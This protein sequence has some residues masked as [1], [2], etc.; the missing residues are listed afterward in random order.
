MPTVPRRGFVASLN[1]E[2]D[3]NDLWQLTPSVSKLQTNVKK[4]QKDN[5]NLGIEGV[6]SLS[7]LGQFK[8]KAAAATKCDFSS[9]VGIIAPYLFDNGK[10]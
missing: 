1:K 7:N 6:G 3:L 2:A 10:V 9:Y 5:W 4:F 8:Y